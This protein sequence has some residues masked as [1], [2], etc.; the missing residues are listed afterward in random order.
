V[1]QLAA[2]LLQQ[3]SLDVFLVFRGIGVHLV[4]H[5]AEDCFLQ[6]QPF[7]ISCFR[8]GRGLDWQRKRHAA[9]YQNFVR[10][11]D[12]VENF[13]YSAIRYCLVNNFLYRLSTGQFLQVFRIPGP[14]HGYL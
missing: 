14:L 9:V 10:G 3:I 8:C 5:L 2:A 13:G 1:R 11:V 6:P 4:D 12:E 7:L